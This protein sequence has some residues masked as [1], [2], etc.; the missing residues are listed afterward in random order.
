MELKEKATNILTKFLVCLF[1]V[2]N[3]NSQQK[4]TIR[5]L[6]EDI[7]NSN[8]GRTE[9]IAN[10]SLRKLNDSE[11]EDIISGRINYFDMK[12]KTVNKIL[13]DLPKNSSNNSI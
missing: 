4:E 10:L 12:V 9:Y 13:E 7:I 6:V 8:N 2:F 3:A 11:K 1:E 5:S